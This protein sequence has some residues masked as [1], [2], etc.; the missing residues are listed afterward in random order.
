[1]SDFGQGLLPVKPLA[2][3]QH[4]EMLLSKMRPL[5]I[6]DCHSAKHN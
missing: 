5:M 1:M 3:T 2:S 6:M 4:T